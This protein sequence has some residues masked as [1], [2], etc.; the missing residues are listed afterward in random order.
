MREAFRSL[1]GLPTY[2]ACCVDDSLPLVRKNNFHDNVRIRRRAHVEMASGALELHE[3]FGLKPLYM[4]KAGFRMSSEFGYE[5][6]K[7]CLV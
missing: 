7:Q 2:C 3:D 1:E 5:R 4:V 6:A